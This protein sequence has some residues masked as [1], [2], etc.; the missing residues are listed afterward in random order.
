MGDFIDLTKTM[1]MST[2]V[3]RV[4]D[5]KYP[6]YLLEFGGP[7]GAGKSETAEEV[8]RML[9]LL[10]GTGKYDIRIL[11]E[12]IQSDANKKAIDDF[13]KGNGSPVELERQIC[14]SRLAMLL[15]TIESHPDTCSLIIVSDRAIED[16]L[17]FIRDLIKRTYLPEN[18]K[19]ELKAIMDN[20]S[21]FVSE[22]DEMDSAIM[23]TTVYLEPTPEEALSRIRKRCRP[24]EQQI[25]KATLWRLTGESDKLIC[26]DVVSIDNSDLTVFETG[27]LSALV[28]WNRLGIIDN[29]LIS[30]YG[31]P[32]VGKSKLAEKLQ[33]WLPMYEP[34]R[35]DRLVTAV[36]DRSDEDD[37]KAEQSLVYEGQKEI[38]MSPDTIQDWIDSRRLGDFESSRS[39]YPSALL[40]IT[41]VGPWT[42]EVFCKATGCSEE[43]SG[44]REWFRNQYHKYLNVIVQPVGG[45]RNVREHI[46]ERG[47]PGEY[48]YFTEE[49]L[50]EIGVLISAHMD[51][52]EFD[53]VGTA[54]FVV[55]GYTKAT[56]SS[57]FRDVMRALHALIRYTTR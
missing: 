36:L 31:V 52:I 25:D 35:M 10:G 38:A 32:G 39:F 49:R 15:K 26:R 11:R 16:D 54:K 53:T 23:H 22:L 47:R 57:M 13:Y 9:G 50:Q 44:Y 34:R 46:K 1:D 28:L 40:T 14:G 51:E 27:T 17:V 7:I 56:L 42:S 21:Q 20:I 19:S 29:V 37:I 5:T 2:L 4:W 6:I 8:Y 55:N 24:N 3:P 30:V 43:H 48:E 33:S 45:Y 41:D 12:D 18:E